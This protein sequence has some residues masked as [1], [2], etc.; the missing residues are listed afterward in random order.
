M[1]YSVKKGDKGEEI[2]INTLNKMNDEQYLINNL[3]LLGDNNVSHQ[4]DHILIR[5]N[6]VFVIET[7]NYYGKISGNIDDLYWTKTYKVHGK[8]KTETFINPIKQ[9]NAHV[10]YIKKI[11]GKDIQLINFVV[12]VNNN[13]SD[14][15]IFKVC[16]IDQL[17]K[18]I[19]TID[20][21]KPLSSSLMKK[22]NDTLLYL[23]ADISND[24][25]VK[26]IKQLKKDRKVR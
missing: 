19:Q 23:E 17:N 8:D 25:H 24:E 20:I 6:G 16:N 4:F 7:K 5:S 14:L 21:D 3:I 22:I 11:L 18:R 15:G 2:V 9:N 26:N 10:R 13:V 1:K 12:F